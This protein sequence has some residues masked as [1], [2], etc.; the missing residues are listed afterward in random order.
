LKYFNIVPSPRVE[1]LQ[2]K[3]STIFKRKWGEMVFSLMYKPLIM[4]II[5]LLVSAKEESHWPAARA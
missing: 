4:M 2:K 1:I 3:Q 5:V